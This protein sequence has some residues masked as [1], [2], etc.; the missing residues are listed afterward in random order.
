MCRLSAFFIATLLLFS[1]MSISFAQQNI[2]QAQ[3]ETDAYR[4]VKHDMKESLWFTTGLVGSSAGTVTGCA[5]GI[6]GGILIGDFNI[7][8]DES[9]SIGGILLFGVLA[10]PICVHLYP[11]SPRPP[12]ERLL[13]KTPEYVVAYTQVYRSKAISLRRTLVTKGSIAGNLGCVVAMLLLYA[14]IY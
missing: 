4:D 9:C 1:T 3:A 11:H 7:L 8:P 14:S 5:S 6:L 13:G 12:P 2:A 10:A